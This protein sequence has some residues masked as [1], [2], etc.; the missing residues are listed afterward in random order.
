MLGRKI[1][2]IVQGEVEKAEGR[3][4]QSILW[5]CGDKHIK[6]WLHLTAAVTEQVTV[7]VSA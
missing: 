6:A 2:D 3:Q 4:T 7:T 1:L 5:A